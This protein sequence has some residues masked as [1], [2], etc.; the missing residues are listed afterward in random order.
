[1]PH[2]PSRGFTWLEVVM[3]LAIMAFLAAVALPSLSDALARHRLRAAA[4]A[5]L[6]TLR[7]SREAALHRPKGTRVCPS[8][9]GRTCSGRTDWG[10]GWISRDGDTN[11]I[12][13]VEDA[14]DARLTAASTGVRTDVVFPHPADEMAEPS[15]QTLA[16]C[17]RGKP[18]TTLT[19][20]VAKNGHS[21]AEPAA[22]EVARACA[23]HHSRIR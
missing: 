18:E 6:D 7:Q 10:V 16:L 4:T 3:V 2:L 23:A 14:L 13:A 20:V 11:A 22:P 19:V 1:M 8:E 21:H 9:N 12:L 5:L 15:N 17:V